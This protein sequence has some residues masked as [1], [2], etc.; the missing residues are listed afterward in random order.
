MSE[1][2]F[3]ADTHFGHANILK[4]TR[5]QFATI[6]EHD[7][8]IIARWNS[9]VRP[10]DT[11]YLLGDAVMNRRCLPT[12]WRLQGKKILIAGNHDDFPAREL[13]SY[14]DD[15]RSLKAFKKHGFVATHVPLHPHCLDRWPVNVHGHLHDLRVNAHQ[16]AV[17]FTDLRYVCVSCEQ[18]DYTPIAL[19]ELLERMNG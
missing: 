19:P 18:V 4:Y 12:L 1:T 16:L 8:H 9:V 5:G 14:F 17:A 2:F 3:I 11:V 7:E 10:N 6:E 15:V 13:L